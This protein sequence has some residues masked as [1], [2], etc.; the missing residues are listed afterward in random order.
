VLQI[1]LFGVMAV[2][3]KRKAPRAHTVLELVRKR[4]GHAANIVRIFRIALSDI[5]LHTPL[6]VHPPE[7]LASA[8]LIDSKSRPYVK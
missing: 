4:W 8:G 6:N 7:L 1:L 3:I 2:E 5:S